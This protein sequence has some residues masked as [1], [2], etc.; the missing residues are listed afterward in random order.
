MSDSTDPE[1]IPLMEDPFLEYWSGHKIQNAGLPE[2][3]AA[4]LREFAV[5]VW[6]AARFEMAMRYSDLLLTVENEVPGETR[7]QTARRYISEC[8]AVVAATKK[9][10][11]KLASDQ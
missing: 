1:S 5:D 6:N 8:D 11:A 9:R 3:A 2:N 10:H 4:E 7:H